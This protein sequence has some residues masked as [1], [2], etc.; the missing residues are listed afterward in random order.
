MPI[1]RMSAGEPWPP[2]WFHV[3]GDVSGADLRRWLESDD[4][5]RISE[6]G[7]SLEPGNLS[8]D[9]V[10][11]IAQPHFDQVQITWSSRAPEL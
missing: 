7:I 11:S 5:P 10:R 6:I 2:I 8:T 4:A 1:S 3:T 9:E